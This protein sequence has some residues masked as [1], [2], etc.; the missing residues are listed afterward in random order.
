VLHIWNVCCNGLCSNPSFRS[1]APSLLAL[2]GSL[3]FPLSPSSQHA[4][5][6][7]PHINHTVYTPLKHH[8]YYL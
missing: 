6:D 2:S 3:L 7:A 8:V 5:Q 1:L 4:L